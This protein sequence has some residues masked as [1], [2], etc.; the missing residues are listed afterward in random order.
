MIE[1]TEDTHLSLSLKPPPADLKSLLNLL[2]DS[3]KGI[4]SL[5]R[6]ILDDMER[7]VPWDILYEPPDDPEVYQKVLEGFLEILETI[8]SRLQMGIQTISRKSSPEDSELIHTAD[9]YFDGLCGM[10]AADFSRLQTVYKESKGHSRVGASA[11][12]YVWEL[13]ADLKGKLTSALMGASASLV[14]RD[15][16]PGILLQSVLFHEKAGEYA[17]N[18]RLLVLLK[19]VSSTMA[20]LMNGAYF[21]KLVN[22]WK[23][24]RRVERYGLSDLWILRGLI[25]KLL[26]RESRRALYSG[27]FHYIERRKRLLSRRIYEIEKL[28][29]R[30]WSAGAGESEPTIHGD[31]LVELTLEVVAVLDVGCLGRLLGPVELEKLRMGKKT[32]SPLAPFVAED[33]LKT[34][35]QLL[36]GNVSKRA[37]FDLKA[38]ESGDMGTTALRQFLLQGGEKESPENAVAAAKKELRKALGRVRNPGHSGA[39]AFR[40]L[41]RLL[42]I[43]RKVPDS[44][45][46]AADPY[47][48]EILRKLVPPLEKASRLE[49]VP[50]ELLRNVVRDS[51]SLVGGRLEIEE[52]GRAIRRL[53]RA[54]DGL[55][56]EIGVDK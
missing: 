34:L 55:V 12:L 51:L 7:K 26:N 2:G 10:L 31:R 14:A 35:F 41:Q 52:T 17:R 29:R 27:D 15:R 8:P 1:E 16:W 42:E 47:V 19:R 30:M 45:L 54:L 56:G 33:D 39:K 32:L 49:L 53:N 20:E 50:A 4:F 28:H 40:L 36:I 3:E 18:E 44:M 37:S 25:G 38:G 43:H 23:E 9:L 48:R 5:A 22:I 24:G 13:T 11:R 21:D 46:A 6:V